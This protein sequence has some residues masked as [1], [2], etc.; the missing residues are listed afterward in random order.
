MIPPLSWH[1]PPENVSVQSFHPLYG[2]QGLTRWM[3]FSFNFLPLAFLYVIGWGGDFFPSKRVQGPD[4]LSLLFSMPL[5]PISSARLYV[6]FFSPQPMS[7]LPSHLSPLF[8]GVFSQLKAFDTGAPVF[9]LFSQGSPH[10]FQRAR[11]PLPRLTRRP[12]PSV[13]LLLG[14]KRDFPLFAVPPA[15][16]PPSQVIELPT[17]SATHKQTSSG[18]HVFLPLSLPDFAPSYF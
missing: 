8:C 1:P 3:V 2:R 4:V 15:I 9:S 17:F 14:V 13:F 12:R 10:F 18:F 6:F 5:A 16:A 11:D 7:P